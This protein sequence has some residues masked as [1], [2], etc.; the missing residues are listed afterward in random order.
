M[1]K[2]SKTAQTWEN[3]WKSWWFTFAINVDVLGVRIRELCRVSHL[4]FS[5]KNVF[6]YLWIWFLYLLEL[7]FFSHKANWVS[8][9]SLGRPWK[10][11]IHVSEFRCRCFKYFNSHCILFVRV[12]FRELCRYILY[13]SIPSTIFELISYK[14]I[15]SACV[16]RVGRPASRERCI[17]LYRNMAR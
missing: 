2:V 7:H 11:L 16:L 4:P 3:N 8:I 14:T 9:W 13:L 15:Y 17:F 10:M 12:C 5:I 6:T 1:L